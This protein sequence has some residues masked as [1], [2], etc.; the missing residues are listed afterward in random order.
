MVKH[1]LSFFQGSFWSLM[2][3]LKN[4]G[5]KTNPCGRNWCFSCS[6]CRFRS[7]VL[8]PKQK[9]KIQ[10]RDTLRNTLRC[11]HLKSLEFPVWKAL[12][13]GIETVGCCRFYWESQNLENKRKVLKTSRERR[14]QKREYHE[15]L[16][17]ALNA[18]I[19]ENNELTIL[20][21][22]NS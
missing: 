13:Q 2:Y 16:S 15:S 11:S 12:G 10:G 4:G 5:L 18:R 9:L 3:V 17:A 21:E 20:R 7:S 22:N 19:E 6:T 14:A 1:A 8:Y